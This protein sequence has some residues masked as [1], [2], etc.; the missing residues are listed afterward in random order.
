MSAIPST[1][2]ALVVNADQNG[3]EVKEHALPKFDDLLVRVHAVALNPTDWKHLA[4]NKPG[5]SSGSD[6]AGVVVKGAG[7]FKE[8]DR[9]AGFTRGGALQQDNGAFA[10]YIA[11]QQ[12]VVWHIPDSVSF[13]QAAA[14]GGIP[15]DVSD[16]LYKTL[17][18][19]TRT[20]LFQTA[21]QA[22]YTRLNIPRPWSSPNKPSVSPGDS[23]LIWSGAASVS[24]YAIQLAKI[25]GLRVYTTASKHHHESLKALGADVVFDYKDPEVSKKIK[26]ASNGTI[27]ICL[28]GISEHGSTKLAADAMS[29]EGGKIIAL[30]SV[31]EQLRSGISV[32]TTLVYSVL[33]SKNVVDRVD[34]AEWHKVVP[35]LLDSGKLRIHNIDR[36]NGGLEAIPEGLNE[37]K[38]GKVS[39]KK[40]VYTLA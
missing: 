27:K 39:G 7:D 31:K 36:K 22:L 24:F 37:L 23:I 29:D 11:A 21:A 20:I 3:W 28:D 2:R 9:V 5:Y 6:F 18:V 13:E 12:P 32:Q 26:E 8:G 38:Q 40:I 16:I 35:E 25:A 17:K 4:F 10:D 34:I 19:H 14:L 15:G 30:L 33:D 1:H